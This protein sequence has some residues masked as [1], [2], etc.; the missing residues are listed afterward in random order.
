MQIC[1]YSTAYSSIKSIIPSAFMSFIL[2]IIVK[3]NKLL[4]KI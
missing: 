3:N 4:F 2:I 1:R